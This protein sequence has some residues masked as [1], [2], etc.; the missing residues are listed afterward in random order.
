VDYD[1]RFKWKSV[2]GFL[3][4]EHESYCGVDVCVN[5]AYT[6]MGRASLA[7]NLPTRLIKLVLGEGIG[8][9]WGGRFKKPDKS[10]FYIP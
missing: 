8:L 6:D 4:V 9:K 3:I 1:T 5:C 2:S 10:H 7:G